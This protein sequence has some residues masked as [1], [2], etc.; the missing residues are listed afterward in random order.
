VARILGLD[1]GSRRVGVA[2]SDATCSIATPYATIC[3]RGVRRLVAE[4]VAVCRDRQVA[5]VVIGLPLHADDSSG[6]AARLPTRVA[7]EMRA[8]GY[9]VDLWDERYTS[10]QAHRLLAGNV[11]AR[12]ARATGM[13]DR[14]A[15]AL[16]LQS[17]LEAADPTGAG[18]AAP[19]DC[20]D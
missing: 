1:V 2:L 14:I 9:R 4:L 8:A 16:I 18:A 5:R 7:E 17:Y 10:V 12:R 19:P 20:R 6:S 11:S 3:H 15:A 13:A